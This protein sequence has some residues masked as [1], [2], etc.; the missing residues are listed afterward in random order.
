[1]KLVGLKM[2]AMEMEKR[3]LMD[4]GQYDKAKQKARHKTELRDEAYAKLDIDTLLEMNGASSLYL[5]RLFLPTGIFSIKKKFFFR[6]I[7]LFYVTI[8]ITSLVLLSLNTIFISICPIF[9][10]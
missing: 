9:D 3:I 7:C 8:M 2:G 4:N 10:N 6:A 5:S 1:M